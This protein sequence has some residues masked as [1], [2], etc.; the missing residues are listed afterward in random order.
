LGTEI[1]SCFRDINSSMEVAGLRS[2][3]L[4]V[5]GDLTFV[6]EDSDTTFSTTGLVELLAVFLTDFF[7]EAI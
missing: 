4:T 7:I 2:T 3:F 1:L 5:S 6:S